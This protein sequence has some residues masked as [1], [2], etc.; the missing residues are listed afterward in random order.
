MLG[1]VFY[2]KLRFI[3][4]KLKIELAGVE[5][6]NIINK[7]LYIGVKPKVFN[8]KYKKLIYK[9]NLKKYKV[10]FLFLIKIFITSSR[11]CTSIFIFSILI[12][13]DIYS[14]YLILKIL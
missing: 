10:F 4:L 2:N 7:I 14:C 8:T 5:V 9:K 12:F 3:I 13:S 11:G 1:C 6:E